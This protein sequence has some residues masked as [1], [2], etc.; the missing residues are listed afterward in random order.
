MAVH[1]KCPGQISQTEINALTWEQHFSRGV[2]LTDRDES[3]DVCAHL[4]DN[5]LYLR[6]TTCLLRCLCVCVCVRVCVCVCLGV[7]VCVCVFV[8]VCVSV[9]V[10][11]T[12]N[13]PERCL[14]R[15][16]VLASPPAGQRGAQPTFARNVA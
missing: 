15:A 13:I 14:L 10:W 16:D 3:K 4:V 5:T 7:S 8:S 2:N 12:L 9:C 11:V 1:S 6:W